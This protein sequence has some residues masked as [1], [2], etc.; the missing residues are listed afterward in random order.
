MRDVRCERER[1]RARAVLCERCEIE[2]VT[3]GPP[4][5]FYHHIAVYGC[6]LMWLECACGDRCA[7]GCA[8]FMLIA[9]PKAWPKAKP[10]S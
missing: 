9:V 5:L 4:R 10:I 1:G 6:V 3:S 7:C 2:R 8:S